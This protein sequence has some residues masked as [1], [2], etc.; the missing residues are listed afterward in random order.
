M[1]YLN[2]NILLLFK[3]VL[4]DRPIFLSYHLF[5]VY[6]KHTKVISNK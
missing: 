2:C 1:Y 5:I 6:N 4:Y 3:V